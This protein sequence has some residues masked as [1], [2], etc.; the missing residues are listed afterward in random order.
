M[1]GGEARSRPQLSDHDYDWE[2]E[3]P[4]GVSL[5]GMALCALSGAVIGGA[6]G[7]LAH[8]FVQGRIFW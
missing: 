2:F 5:L 3:D 4:A 8:G 1:D 7:W 6:I